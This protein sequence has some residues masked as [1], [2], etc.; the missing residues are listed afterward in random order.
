MRFEAGF[1]P[2]RQSVRFWPVREIPTFKL[3]AENRPFGS[4]RRDQFKRNRQRQVVAGS[5]PTK[6]CQK[7]ATRGQTRVAA[8]Y[9]LDFSLLR[10]LQRIVYLDTEVANGAFQLG[11]AK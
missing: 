11:M 9:R 4:A 5:T 6:R 2:G 1:L 10:N 7:A 3:L 8:W